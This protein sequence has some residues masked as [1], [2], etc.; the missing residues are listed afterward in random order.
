MVVSKVKLVILSILII[1]FVG[2]GLCIYR[3][4]KNKAEIECKEQEIQVKTKTVEV[5]KY[6][7][8]DN[9]KI[10]LRPNSTFQEIL[11]RMKKGEI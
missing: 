7:Y 1:C 10:Y 8:K 9:A 2:L 6:V 5:I 3:L 4:G 11:D